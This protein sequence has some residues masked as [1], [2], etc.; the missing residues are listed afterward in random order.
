MLSETEKLSRLITGRNE[1]YFQSDIDSSRRYF[2]QEI[3]G[4]T[5][6][7]PGG[8]GSIGSAF[9][10][11][12]IPYQPACIIIIDPD[13]NAL[14]HCVRSIRNSFLPEAL[15]EIKTYSISI[16]HIL[17]QEWLNSQK[18]IDYI[19]S[20]AARKH[21][22]A[23]RD[24]Y[25]SLAMLECNILAHQQLLECLSKKKVKGVFFVSTDKAADP[26][27][28]MGASKRIMEQV[29]FSYSDCFPVQ[30]LRFAN[31]LFSAGSI[32]ESFLER[33]RSHQAFACPGDVSRYF[34]SESEAGH[35]C[36]LSA[37]GQSTENIWIPTLDPQ[38]HQKPLI[39]ALL[40]LL[41]DWGIVPFYC[42]DER[43]A[44]YT[45]LHRKATEPWPILITRTNTSGEKPYEIFIGKGEKMK[46]KSLYTHLAAVAPVKGNTK[47]IQQMLKVIH[48]AMASPEQNMHEVYEWM[49]AACPGFVA[50]DK[51][52]SL[53]DKV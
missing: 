38:K 50:P 21:V 27:S 19:F 36:L 31:V 11:A 34:I 52:S 5:W 45:A 1:S 7:I 53:D 35:M 16:G 9:I 37:M 41:V 18:P 42:T 15:P 17:F 44:I 10:H 47:S 25:S 8:A 40:P 28:L 43:E 13:E 51:G 26:A 32:T 29:L 3:P 49:Q 6:L 30:T 24:L 48:H 22:R 46:P 14:A 33:Y 39:E 12:L 4:S 23:E 20:F 2:E